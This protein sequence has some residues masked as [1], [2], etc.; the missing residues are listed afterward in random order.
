MD[1]GFQVSFME[2]SE[3]VPSLLLAFLTQNLRG[4]FPTIGSF[5]QGT[6]QGSGV[7][8]GPTGVGSRTHEIEV[9]STGLGRRISDFVVVVRGSELR[10]PPDPGREA[11]LRAKEGSHERGQVPWEVW[12]ASQDH[13]VLRVKPQRAALRQPSRRHPHRGDVRGK[14]ANS[15]PQRSSDQQSSQDRLG[16]RAEQSSAPAGA[17]DAKIEPKAN[18]SPEGNQVLKNRQGI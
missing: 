9:L 2:A 6:A 3:V 12:C 5:E 17:P 16:H 10:P 13:W 4:R 18:T 8:Q 15:K 7:A 11:R 14:F 1:Q